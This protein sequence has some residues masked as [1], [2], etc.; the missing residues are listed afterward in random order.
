MTKRVDEP[1]VVTFDRGGRPRWFRW[2]RRRVAI[3]QLLDRW[4]EAGCWWR[5]EEV[6]RVYRVCSRKGVVYELHHQASQGWRLYR[7]YD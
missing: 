1:V 6:R 5:G 4:E 2:G 7:I 3:G